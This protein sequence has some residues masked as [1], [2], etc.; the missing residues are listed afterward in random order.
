MSDAPQVMYRAYAHFNKRLFD[1]R[2]PRNMKIAIEDL[3]GVVALAGTAGNWLSTGVPIKLSSHFF[4]DGAD[5]D[6]ATMVHEM[7]HTSVGWAE[8][9]SPKWQAEMRRIGFEADVNGYDSVIPGGPFDRACTEF[10]GF[11]IG[12]SKG[13]KMTRITFLVDASESMYLW[14][15]IIVAKAERLLA[16]RPGS[17]LVAF[18][19]RAEIL[20]SPSDLY[21]VCHGTSTCANLGPNCGNDLPAALLFVRRNMHCDRLILITDAAEGIHNALWGPILH[22]ANALKQIGCRIET[23]WLPQPEAVAHAASDD[24][25]MVSGCGGKK[26]CTRSYLARAPE[27]LSRVAGNGGTLRQSR[28]SPEWIPDASVSD[29][30]GGAV[31]AVLNDNA[32]VAHATQT[33]PGGS[34]DITIFNGNSEQLMGIDLVKGADDMFR[35]AIR[36]IAEKHQQAVTRYGKNSERYQREMQAVIKPALDGLAARAELADTKAD[37][38]LLTH[39]YDLIVQKVRDIGAIGDQID[40]ISSRQLSDRQRQFGHTHERS[41]QLFASGGHAL[42]AAF[43]NDAPQVREIRGE[44]RDRDRYMQQHRQPSR[45]ISAAPASRQ[46]ISGTRGTAQVARQWGTV[47]LLTHQES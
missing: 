29:A 26:W 20:E 1:G 41:E 19:A 31:T 32:A 35:T 45:E 24:Q 17:I 5:S 21:R 38:Q 6:M 3:D 11:P 37:L 12:E 44:W 43:N 28:Q 30:V 15:G 27:L 4:R 34:R 42:S 2:L 9:H 18:R 47:R 36:V 7:A 25:S 14:R 13:R 23:V 10:L 8:W 40:D 22:E 39:A 46:R 16:A 33:Q